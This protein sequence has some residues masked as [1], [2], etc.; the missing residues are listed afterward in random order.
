[1]RGMSL[2]RK[3]NFDISF[4]CSD[5]IQYGCSQNLLNDLSFVVKGAL[6]AILYLGA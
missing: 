4:V 2:R 6:K 3:L 5:K 1:M